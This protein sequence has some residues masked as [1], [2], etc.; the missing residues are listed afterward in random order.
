M[1]ILKQHVV[2]KSQ[3][4]RT[5]CPVTTKLSL[6]ITLIDLYVTTVAVIL[7]VSEVS[8]TTDITR[9]FSKTLE[10]YSTFTSMVCNDW[11]LFCL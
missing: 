6:A 8:H 9:E 10:N 2:L 11:I 7:A 5:L 1:K 3:G 4:R